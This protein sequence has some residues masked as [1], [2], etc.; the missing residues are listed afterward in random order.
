MQIQTDRTNLNIIDSTK[1]F[2]FK[3][4]RVKK[5]LRAALEAFEF[6][7]LKISKKTEVELSLTLCGAAKIKSLNRDFRSKNYVTDVLSF[8]MQDDFN[9]VANFP[10]IEIGDIYICKEKAISQ[11][12]EFKVSVEDEII[13]LFVHG[14]LHLLGFD[15]EINRAEELKMA[16]MEQ[17]ILSLVSKNIR[18]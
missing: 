1:T 12:K 4:A 8:Q 13:H 10:V 15:H 18:K 3:K 7:K 6:K 17:E 11:S 14:F 2:W 5:L 9:E 16:K